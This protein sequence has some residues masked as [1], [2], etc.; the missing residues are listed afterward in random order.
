LTLK[1]EKFFYELCSI[2][3][4]LDYNNMKE[5]FFPICL[6][7]LKMNRQREFRYYA[8]KFY[9]GLAVMMQN[10][11]ISV[12]EY[13]TTEVLSK[14]QDLTNLLKEMTMDDREKVE[15]LLKTILQYVSKLTEEKKTVFT[16]FE[17][18]SLSTRENAPVKTDLPYKLE[19]VEYIVGKPVYF[20][21]RITM[22]QHAYEIM[23]RYSE[24]SD[25]NAELHKITH[26]FKFP[27][28]PEKIII[29]NTQDS[30]LEERKNML[31]VYMN[32]ICEMK[33]FYT[34][35]TFKKFI[36]KDD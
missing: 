21:L 30:K 29:G 22:D 2:D 11:N 24:F 31:N 10:H 14:T 18:L 32:A 3:Q 36:R 28:F 19:I 16:Q 13:I 34:H 6:D 25:F 8:Q 15:S 27:P 7:P 9:L 4:N 5:K 20:R 12:K 23:K 17:K 33:D 1:I 35:P 26:K